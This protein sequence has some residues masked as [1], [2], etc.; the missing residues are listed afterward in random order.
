MNKL[1]RSPPA[2]AAD[3]LDKV[4]EAVRNLRD[5]DLESKQLSQ[6]LGEVQA[7]LLRQQ[8]EVLPDL[9]SE[10]GVRNLTLA[11]EG[12]LP[13]VTARLAPYYKAGIGSDWEP[14]RREE[15]FETLEHMGGGDL[16]KTQFIVDLDRGDNATAKKIEDGLKRMGIPFTRQLSVHWKTL[17]SFVQEQYESKPPKILPLEKLGA[18]VGRRVTLKPER[19]PRWQKP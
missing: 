7:E 16:I 8:H 4:R 17:T 6:R 11:P 15:A 12:N 3:K 13:A 9:F 5:L 19:E 1:D 14:E 10:I 2:P 18:V